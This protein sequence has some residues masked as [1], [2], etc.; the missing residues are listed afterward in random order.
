[1][2]ELKSFYRKIESC[3]SEA[4]DVRS[5]VRL[6]ACL[7]PALLDRL[8][9]PLGLA[10]AHVYTGRAD[11]LEQSD[12]WGAGRP[13]L[14]K[15]LREI[16]RSTSEPPPWLLDTPAGRAGA[17]RIGDGPF[18]AL[19]GSHPGELRPEPSRGEF[20]SAL[21]SIQYAIEQH[22]HR[23]EMATAIEQ[24]RAIQQSL[25]PPGRGRFAGFDLFAASLPASDVGGDLYDYVVVDTDVL[26][27]VVADSS[28]HGLPAALQARDVAMG[29]RMGAERDLKLTRLVEKLN[30][31]IHR[32]GLVTRFISMVF[33]ELEANGNFMYVN[34][35]HPP[36]LLLDDGGVKELAVGG[37]VLGPIADASYKMG[38]SHIDRGAVLALYSDGVV[39][40]RDKEGNEFGMDR[41][42]AWL[43]ES[44]EREAEASVADL[45]ERLRAHHGSRRAFEDD[46]TV[47]L[48]R[49]LRA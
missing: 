20:V 18:L 35:G 26:G 32:S 42:V 11:Q 47:M 15:A 17:V 1:M 45:I 24:A 5:P 25:L 2:I 38:F 34:A 29:V 48:V 30:R 9:G 8:A 13:D 7:G 14:A 37:P 23:G 10:A 39:E 44:R 28:G 21:H 22:L 41:I 46:V 3:F 19:F 40:C 27:L 31:I 12:S 16:A 6:A 4:G 33:G 43:V 49:R 36:A